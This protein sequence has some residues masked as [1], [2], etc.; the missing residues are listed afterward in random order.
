MKYIRNRYGIYPGL[1]RANVPPEPKKRH[2]EFESEAMTIEE[3]IE[4]GDLISYGSARFAKVKKDEG[5]KLIG[6]GMEAISKSDV[7]AVWIPVGNFE[8]KDRCHFKM[9]AAKDEGEEN[10]GT[11]CMEVETVF[12]HFPANEHDRKEKRKWRKKN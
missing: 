10:L 2:N 5:D 9:V 12:L 4:P 7:T 11:V 8:R 3:L 1:Y 6:E